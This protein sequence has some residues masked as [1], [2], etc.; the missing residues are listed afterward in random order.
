MRRI[1]PAAILLFCL[2]SC[3]YSPSKILNRRVTL[4]RKDKIPYGDQ[5]A[6]EGL[7]HLFPDATISLNRKAPSL[8]RSGDGKKAYI[9][10]V[11]K[12]DPD[13][14]DIN[15][16]LNFVGEGN[17]VFISARRY[18]DSLLRTLSIKTGFGRGMKFEPD[19]MRLSL[20]HPVTGDFESYAYPGDAYDNWVDSLDS[21][22][23]TVLGRDQ[24]GRP[25]LVRFNYKGGGALYLHFAP[26]A[27]SNF[28][29]LHKSNIRYYEH[30]L[31]YLPS[32]VQEVIW[33]DYFRY[34]HTRDFSAFGFILGGGRNSANRGLAWGFW[35]LLLL[36]A[37]IYIFDSKRKQRAIPVIG[38]LRN[39][40][41]DF[42][43]TIGR[44]YFQRRDNFNLAIKMV[45]HFQDQVRTRYN[46]PAT[47]LD[48]I[49]VQRLSYKTGAPPEEMSKLVGYM[50]ELPS[51]AYVPDEELLDFH[52]QLEAFYK[53]A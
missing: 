14:A 6:Y 35:L 29:L 20:Y 49:F 24:N 38:A 26:L 2:A 22:Y 27:F 28:F 12:M 53:L 19:S 9:V 48:E 17:Q 10:I 44:L 46:L 16:I 5:I 8:L 52:R 42:V 25:N 33:D 13:P 50:R 36:F 4:W 39:T 40:S 23:A 1:I 18:G 21:K 3:R 34:D 32:T 15:A 43:Q 30:T 51:K 37:I 31:S 47:A 45:A 7:S 11:P 41:L